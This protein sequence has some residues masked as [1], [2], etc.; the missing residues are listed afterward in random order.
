MIG[1]GDCVFLSKPTLIPDQ[2]LI[3]KTE[4]YSG[5]KSQEVKNRFQIQQPHVDVKVSES[6]TGIY[7]TAYVNYSNRVK[8]YTI[9]L[10]FSYHFVTHG[11]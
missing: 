9:T 6:H 2:W 8:T 5:V 1:L 10:L 4:F 11:R 3:L 7:M